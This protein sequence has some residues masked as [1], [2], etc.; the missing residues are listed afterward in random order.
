MK[1][2]LLQNKFSIRVRKLSFMMLLLV[3]TIGAN[4]NPVD[5]KTAHKAAQSFFNSKMGSN[6]EIELIDFAEKASFSNFYIFGNDHSFVIIAADDCVHPV[7]GYS[8]DNAFGTDAMPENVAGWLKAYNDDVALAVTNKMEA[9]NDIREEWANL[10]SGKGLTPKSRASVAPLVRTTWNQTAPYNNLCPADPANDSSWYNGHVPT[11][12]MATAM[13]QILNYWEHPVRGV[14][15]HSYIPEQHPEYGEQFADF[16]ATTYDWDNMKNNYSDGYT[17]D[18]ANAVA[19]LMYHCGVSID[20]NYKPNGSGG[21]DVTACQAFKTYFNY[22]PDM[23]IVKKAIRYE[24]IEYPIYTDEEWKMMMKVEL[25]NNR[26][27]CYVGGYYISEE[28]KGTHAF[29]CDGYDENDLFH[30]NFGWGGGSDGYYA[31]G[32]LNW[33]SGNT[34]QYNQ[35]NKFWRDCFPCTPSINPPTNVVTTVS[36]RNVSIQWNGVSEASSYRL[37]RDGDLL[38]N[39]LTSTSYTDSNLLYGT[40]SYYVKSVMADGTMS[41][42]SDLS[43]AEV[44]F[45]GPVPTDL[46]TTVNNNNV[47]LSWTAPLS[48]SYVLS[49]GEGPY[50]NHVGYGNRAMYWAQRYPVQLLSDHVTGM[51]INK[52]SVYSHFNDIPIIA[53][54][55]KGNANAPEELLYQ[56]SKTLDNSGWQDIIVF[57]PVP[58]DYS[59]DL[60]IV[61]YADSTVSAPAAYCPYSGTGKEDA[62]YISLNGTSYWRWNQERSWMIRT[63]ATDGTYTYNLY[64]NGDVIAN[65]LNGNTYSDNNLPDDHYAY[66]VTTNYYGGES[67]ASNVVEV[68]IG[69]PQYTISATASPSMGGSVSGGGIFGYGQT[70]TLTAMANTDYMFLNWSEGD[71]VVSTNA[72]YSFLVE[73]NRNLKANFVPQYCMISV[74][75]SYGGSVSGGGICGYGQTCTLT[76]IPNAGYLFTGWTKDG[77][78]VSTNPTI[79]FEVIENA[80]YM[81]S[82]TIASSGVL[83]G[84]FSVGNS[85][86]VQFSQGNLQYQA[87]TDTWRFATNQYDCIGLYN[88]GISPFYSGWIDL[89]GWGTSSYDHGAVCY[90]PWSTSTENSDYYV[91]GNENYHLY[92]Q[93]GQ[94]EWG[95]NSISNG[96]NKPNYWRTLTYGE[97]YYLFYTRSTPSNIR[98]VKAQV[99]NTNGVILLPDDWNATIYNLNNTNSKEASFS[100]N[101]ISISQWATLENAG[102]VF[103]PAAGGRTETTVFHLGDR[104]YYWSSSS[105]ITNS[106]NNYAVALSFGVNN[107]GNDFLGF[108]TDARYTGHSVRLVREVVTQT[109]S[110]PQGTNWFSTHLDITLDD[111][112]A[113]L[114]AAM[115][116]TNTPITIKSKTQNVKYQNGRWTGSLTTLDMTQMYKIIVSEAC[117]ISLEGLPID[118]T[119]LS[120]TITPGANWIAF[121]YSESMS[122]TDFFG[123]FPVTNDVVKSKLQNTR[124]NNGRW[125]GQLNTLIPGQG[126]IYNSA[127]TGNRT[128]TFPTSAK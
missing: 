48:D 109:V 30:F 103:L 101:V 69:N 127:A 122:V 29:I 3:F 51:A 86:Q 128:F 54:I 119:T 124:Y 16:G 61:L 71:N 23:Y 37:Y 8:M 88:G 73:S 4:A 53:Y 111:L 110:L 90:Q 62:L 9:T 26:P 6:P 27:L 84:T 58:I 2:K 123:S 96:G 60:W 113:A 39:D 47:N 76:A 28:E 79:V 17:E 56:T 92:D 115:S 20:M 83:N 67:D 98:F 75:A 35:Y 43:V 13:A 7:L 25:N 46:Q 78:L 116:G 100:S 85:K 36:G 94:A 52:I 38:A 10:L 97:W 24:G 11:G 102:A 65:N 77:E 40:Y 125:A 68:L 80:S 32:A 59:N 112:K 22:N 89:F 104:A 55:Y 44:I 106:G 118:P 95:Y 87:S 82:F 117:E 15:S 91:Y 74:S 14:G 12:C 34:Q 33:G 64:R 57:N 108:Y 19:T 21:S 126:Y 105:W 93:T 121:P 63:Y 5:M 41:L 31:I 120:L 72:T 107:Q 50:G 49:Y 18:E 45:S 70:C 42:M 99:N 114:V 81:A 66:Y 1:I